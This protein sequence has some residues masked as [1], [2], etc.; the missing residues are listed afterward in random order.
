MNPTNDIRDIKGLVPLL[1]GYGWLWVL[2]ALVVLGVAAWFLYRWWRRRQLPAAP[3]SIPVLSPYDRAVRALQ[4]LLDDQLMPRGMADEFYTRLSDIVRHY[5]E[6]RFHL[7]APE[8]T[9]EEFLAEVS[10]SDALTREHKELLGA[11]LQECD[12]V[13]FARFRPGSADMQR[14]F[15]AAERF[16]HDTRRR[17]REEVTTA[18]GR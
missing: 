12:L 16:V 6:G 9:T 10:Q 2:A 17:L 7:H 18:G 8:R 3:P 13:K 15:E 1:G 14:A 4:R 5:L 11:F